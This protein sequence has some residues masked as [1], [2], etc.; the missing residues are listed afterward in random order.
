VIY[1]KAISPV[2]LPPASVTAVDQYAFKDAVVM[3][4]GISELGKNI[5]RD[6]I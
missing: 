3:G 1:T 6:L 4:W 5:M 2:C